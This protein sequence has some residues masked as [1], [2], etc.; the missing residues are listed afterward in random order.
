MTHLPPVS[1]ELREKYLLVVGHGARNSFTEMVE[2]SSMISRKVQETNSRFLLVD[3][4]Y[5]KVNVAMNQAFNIVKR[6]ELKQPEIKTL[7]MAAVFEGQGLE[8]G[9]YWQKVGIQRG[10]YIEVFIDIE[11]A[12]RWLLGKIESETAG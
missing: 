11:E 9:R 2:A 4:R 3:Y 12:E 6:Y 1:F 8:F 7:T 10:F 5:L